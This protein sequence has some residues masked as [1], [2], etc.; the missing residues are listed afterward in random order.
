MPRAPRLRARGEPGRSAARLRRNRFSASFRS[1]ERRRRVRK[2]VGIG[3][4]LPA[5]HGDVHPAKSPWPCGSYF[6]DRLAARN[7]RLPRKRALLPTGSGFETATKAS[8]R[9]FAA[10]SHPRGQEKNV[11]LVCRES[12][13][14][15]TTPSAARRLRGWS[16]QSTIPCKP[17]AVFLLSLVG[18]RRE[19]L[20]LAFV[21]VS[22]PDPVGKFSGETSFTCRQRSK[23]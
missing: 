10:C 21:A 15:L 23:K 12:L 6:L 11:P 3:C 9:G 13:I 14:V 19:P 8:G 4:T 5:G 7:A 1:P 17:M 18:T 2:C 20:P 22:K 16:E